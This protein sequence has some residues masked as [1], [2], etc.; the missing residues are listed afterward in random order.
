MS[1]VRFLIVCSEEPLAQKMPPE[2]LRGHYSTGVLRGEEGDDGFQRRT[3][4]V[5]RS[6]RPG[7]SLVV[8]VCLSGR[9]D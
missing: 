3:R 1:L 6:G 5:A 8:E 7:R 4:L 2:L 9:G